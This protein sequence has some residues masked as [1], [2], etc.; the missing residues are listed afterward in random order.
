[1]SLSLGP[2]QRP[3]ATLNRIIGGKSEQRNLLIKVSLEETQFLAFIPIYLT[4][5]LEKGADAT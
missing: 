5:I 4:M 3:G 1:M 2:L